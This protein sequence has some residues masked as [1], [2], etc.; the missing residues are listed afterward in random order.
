MDIA[1]VAS[2]MSQF[3]LANQVGTAMLGKSMDTAE[4]V[5]QGIASMIN[6]VPTPNLGG[7]IDIRL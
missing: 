1:A 2:N 4:M 5:G 7:T 3:T 6:S